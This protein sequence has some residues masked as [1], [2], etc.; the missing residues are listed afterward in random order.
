MWGFGTVVVS[1]HP[2]VAVGERLYGYFAPTR[3]LVLHI[4]EKDV[5]KY[6]MYVPRN[7]LPAGRSD[8]F[9]F[10]SYC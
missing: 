4:D 1:T 6:S 7:H 9:V 8:I 5:N 3:Y 10:D 2:K